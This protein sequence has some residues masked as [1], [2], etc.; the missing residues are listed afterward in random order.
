[1]VQLLVRRQVR[2]LG[3]ASQNSAEWLQA[4]DVIPIEYGDGLAERLRQA[5]P[6]GIDAFIDLFG[7]DYVQLAVDLG[8]TRA[9]R[10]DHLLPEG[11]RSGRQNR[12]QH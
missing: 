9:D 12:R 2:V 1:V 11:S 10:D 5:A 4:H 7:P 8:T 3:I 6:N